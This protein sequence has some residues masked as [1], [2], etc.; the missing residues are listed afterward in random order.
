MNDMPTPET[1]ADGAEAWLARVAAAGPVIEAAA[2]EAD[3]ARRLTDAAMAALHEQRLF[4]LLLPRALGG[5]EISLPM[6]FAVIEAIAGYDAS[7]AWCVC[8]GNGCAML[9]AYLDPSVGKAIW[10]DDP[11]GVLAWG[12]GKVE[13]RAVEGGYEVTGRSAFVSG[14]NHATWLAAHCAKWSLSPPER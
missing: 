12:P 9:G 4:R 5:E 6:F 11:A 7:A 14:A 10:A 2:A 8:Q 13:A 3:R 1:A